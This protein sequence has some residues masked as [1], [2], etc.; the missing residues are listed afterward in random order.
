VRM[1]TQTRAHLDGG[2]DD[3]AVGVLE[4]RHDP[5][6]DVLGLSASLSVSLGLPEAG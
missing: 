4:L 3:A 2:E 6:A 1:G 5:L